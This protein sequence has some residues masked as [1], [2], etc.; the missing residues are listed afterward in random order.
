MKNSFD[1]SNNC[2]QWRVAFTGSVIYIIKARHTYIWSSYFNEKLTFYHKE[3]SLHQRCSQYTVVEWVH[4]SHERCSHYTIV[5]GRGYEKTML[6]L[7]RFIRSNLLGRISPWRDSGST[8]GLIAIIYSSWH[9]EKTNDPF[10]LLFFISTM[11]WISFKSQS[12]S[13]PFTSMLT[14]LILF[15]QYK[16]S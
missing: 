5:P 4:S 9:V 12:F 14:V 6:C 15:H 10:H 1:S 16:Y 11:S 13:N 2:F 8:T 7:A 3:G